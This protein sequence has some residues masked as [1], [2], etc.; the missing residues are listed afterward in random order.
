MSET[1]WGYWL[2]LL[3]VFVIGV[4]LLVNNISTTN[5]QDYYNIKEVTQASMIDAVDF[6]YYRLYGNVKISEQKFV[7][8]FARRFA[9]NINMA[10]AYNIEF[11][12]LYE[13][14]PK[15]SVK[16]STGTRSFNIGQSSASYDVVTTLSAILEL[17]AQGSG[18]SGVSGDTTN[19][20]GKQCPIRINNA[21]KSYLLG[22]NTK[23]NNTAN[24]Y[25]IYNERSDASSIVTSAKN[26]KIEDM[27]I[28]EFSSWFAKNYKINGVAYETY[29][30]QH[31][32]DKWDNLL[33]E[34][35]DRGWIIIVS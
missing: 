19:P 18:D 30:N 24:T 7:E 12:D 34:F 33:K 35:L 14:P 9:E 10:N 4:M 16:I 3:G 13:V 2:I 20:G 5:T 28:A 26:A 17:G 25:N 31:E 8:N 21:L 11:F 29:I 32:Y 23:S 1:Y 27:G 15:V 6:S 22:E